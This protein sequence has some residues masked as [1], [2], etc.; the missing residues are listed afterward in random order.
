MNVWP[1]KVLQQEMK[2]DL[3]KVK[4]NIWRIFTLLAFVEYDNVYYNNSGS[5]QTQLENFCS[6]SPATSCNVTAVQ[7]SLKLHIWE[8][9]EFCACIYVIWGRETQLFDLQGSWAI[10]NAIWEPKFPTGILKLGS[11]L[12][13]G[14]LVFLLQLLAFYAFNFIYFSNTKT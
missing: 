12:G 3:K 4:E 2:G 14:I 1:P 8:V 10:Q 13:T 11:S 6:L 9:R 5:F 7:Q